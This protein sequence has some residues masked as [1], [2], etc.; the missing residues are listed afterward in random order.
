MDSWHHKLIVCKNWY[1][2]NL[3][4]RLTALFS[5]PPMRAPYHLHAPSYNS[6]GATLHFHFS[7]NWLCQLQ[8]S[9]LRNLHI[10]S[11]VK[12]T[13]KGLKDR[14]CKRITLLKHPQILMSPRKTLF[15]RGCLPWR[16]RVSRPRL[17][18]ARNYESPSFTPGHMK[19]FSCTWDL[20]W[21][22]SRKEDTSRPTK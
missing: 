5:D 21:T 2:N 11:P 15:K 8:G 16:L 3:K 14:K 12:A 20:L 13:A 22:Q 4:M 19:H 10:M 6:L 1:K 17:A 9:Y 18:K 7:R